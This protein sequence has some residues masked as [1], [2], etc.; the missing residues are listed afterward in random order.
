MRVGIGDP[1]DRAS[2]MSGAAG[3]RC[4]SGPPADGCVLGAGWPITGD[5]LTTGF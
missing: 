4:V 2:V 5:R 1:H 3:P